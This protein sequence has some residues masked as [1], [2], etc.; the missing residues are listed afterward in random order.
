M[1]LTGAH[2]HLLVNHVPILGALFAL[3][4]L[5]ASFLW[6][7][8]V[9]ARTALVVLVGAAI[10]AGIADLTGDAAKDAVRGLPGVRRAVIHAH[11]EMGDKAWIAAGVLGLAALVGL[12][13]WRRSPVPRGAQVGYTA[14]AVVLSGIM[15]YTGLLGGQVRHTEVRPGATRADA[16]TIEPP[17]PGPPGAPEDSEPHQ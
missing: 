6:A 16:M 4:L 5:V 15:V 13:R 9:L 3:G 8:D 10:A 12:W 14:G 11:E 2:I 7:R 17:R 1:N